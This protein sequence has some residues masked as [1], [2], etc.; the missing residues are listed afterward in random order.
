MTIE[1][2]IVERLRGIAAVTALVVNRIYLL[3]APQKPVSPFLLV[4]LIDDLPQYHLRGPYGMRPA[5]IQVDAY[6]E[7]ASGVDFQAQANLLAAAVVG[8]W[9]AGS[10]GPPTGLAGWIGVLGGSPAQFRIG[11]IRQIDRGVDYEAEELRLVRVR[12]DF[13]VWWRPL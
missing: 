11:L 7:D 10:P 3:K 13:I 1:E 12:Q 5:R 2:A 9:H 4:R 8:D 6:A